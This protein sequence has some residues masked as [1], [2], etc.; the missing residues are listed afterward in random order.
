[1]EEKQDAYYPNG[2]RRF[3]ENF[4]QDGIN[5]VKH[6]YQ[7][8][9]D[10]DG[11][12]REKSF[13]KKGELQ[14][15]FLYKD[16]IRQELYYE[17]GKMVRRRDIEG[18]KT[19][20][21]FFNPEGELTAT[22]YTEDD[23]PLY[24]IL[25]NGEVINFPYGMRLSWYNNGK[26]EEEGI[27]LRGK[28]EG[29][30]KIYE[31]DGKLA[32]LETYKEGKLEGLSE[33]YY[34]NGKIRARDYYHNNK[35]NVISTSWDEDG[36]PHIVYYKDG[37]KINKKKYHRLF[38]IPP[39]NEE[40]KINLIDEYIIGSQ[41]W[42]AVEFIYL[43]KRYQ[44]SCVFLPI[45]IGTEPIR[46]DVIFDLSLNWNCERSYCSLKAPKLF[47][48]KY[49]E[50]GFYH[51]SKYLSECIKKSERL[52]VIPMLLWAD[53]S[54]GHANLLVYDK[55]LHTLERFEPHGVQS[56]LNY[57]TD[58][59][60][61]KLKSFFSLITGDTL[62]LE[63]FPPES[64]CPIMGPQKCENLNR[65]DEKA[66]FEGGLCTVWIFVYANFRLKFPDKTR[67]EINTVITDEICSE[68][69]YR[70]ARRVTLLIYD[71]YLRIK[72][73]KTPEE[74]EKVINSEILPWF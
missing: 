4:I 1:M 49:R 7:T 53:T 13:Y 41:L 35:Q 42:V 40:D 58:Q 67:D 14:H 64:F 66:Y 25:Q 63:Y 16:N 62:P 55:K 39:D 70:F 54:T 28:K 12:V 3:E 30:H 68:N 61:K 22:V 21:S 15:V 5:E 20:D 36:T 44:D 31:T 32:V 47:S 46:T 23:I 19:T 71:F 9:W 72:S 69:P 74:L 50:N 29:V 57:H 17:D 2:Q 18:P 34:E 59:L 38:Q 73:A 43:M 45:N 60:D 8:I 51:Y 27:F 10:E 48:D 56:P 26:V 6:G 11:K 24:E 52:S 65:T 37:V 33:I